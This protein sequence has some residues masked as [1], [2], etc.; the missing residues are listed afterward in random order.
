MDAQAALA[1]YATMQ[2]LLAPVATICAGTAAGGAALLVAAG[3]PGR[4]SATPSAQFLLR[5]PEGQ[6]SGRSREVEAAAQRLLALRAQLNEL[7]ARHTGQTLSR[8]GADTERRLALSADAA[9]I[10]GL[11]DRITGPASSRI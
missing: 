11:I 9:L 2:A 10:Y 5:E 3:T 4:R 6:I 8:I 1:V 7:L